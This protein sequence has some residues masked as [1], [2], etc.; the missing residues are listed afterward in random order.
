MILDKQTIDKLVNEAATTV[1]IM[2]VYDMA[3]SNIDLEAMKAAEAEGI[4]RDD[5]C[6]NM[7]MGG[8]M[9][10]IRFTLENLDLKEVEDAAQ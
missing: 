10:G 2:D 4:T 7:A 1:P 3:L 5:L 8:F 9:A 6:A